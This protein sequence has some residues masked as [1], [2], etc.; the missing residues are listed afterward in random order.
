M[1][2]SKRRILTRKIA[3]PLS[4]T[5]ANAVEY[6]SCAIKSHSFDDN[7]KKLLSLFGISGEE[8]AEAG[9]TWEELKAVSSFL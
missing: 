1:S 9:L 5:R 7:A 3:N 6:V 2:K 4:C 8:L